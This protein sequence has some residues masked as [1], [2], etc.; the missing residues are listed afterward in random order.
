MTI[1][2]IATV[3]DRRYLSER[4]MTMLANPKRPN[5]PTAP[6]RSSKR[7]RTSPTRVIV[8]QATRHREDSH[9]DSY[10]T[11]RDVTSCP[12]YRFGYTP[13]TGHSNSNSRPRS[14]RILG[15]ARPPKARLPSR[16][17]I[18]GGETSPLAT[19]AECPFVGIGVRVDRLT[20]RSR[21]VVIRR[22]AAYT[23]DRPYAP[24][25][26]AARRDRLVAGRIAG[27]GGSPTACG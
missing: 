13:P 5:Q 18:R 25:R 2:G 24:V 21:A 17:P 7:W 3:S 1:S 20:V 16:P 14:D 23:E 11:R 26:C 22:T 6:I 19:T 9:A 4:S 10:T 8:Q 12:G 27:A 15:H